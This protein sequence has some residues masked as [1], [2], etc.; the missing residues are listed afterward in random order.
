MV[1]DK[2]AFSHNVGVVFPEDGLY[3]RRTVLDN[4]LISCRIYGLAKE[5]AGTVI[6]LIG[7]ADQK[8]VL[9]SKLIGSL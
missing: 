6:E 7:L 3:Q 4:L 5:R 1:D 9:V 2:S 8:N